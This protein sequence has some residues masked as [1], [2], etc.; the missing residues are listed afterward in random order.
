ML[1]VH[2]ENA[3]LKQLRRS[4][5]EHDVV[6]E[7]SG[8][9]LVDRITHVFNVPVER[10]LEDPHT[11]ATA[12]M[13]VRNVKSASLSLDFSG[14]QLLRGAI[15]TPSAEAADRIQKTIASAQISFAQKYSQ[16]GAAALS[17]VPPRL[18]EPLDGTLKEALHDFG[19]K[20]MEKSVTL[21]LP[22]PKSWP[23]LVVAAAGLLGAPAN[24]TK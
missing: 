13:V 11:D 8:E 12:K 18:R 23:D 4:D 1:D 9:A 22:S 10:F 16:N 24:A 20:A 5:F 6:F 7:Y 2:K 17:Q 15:T 3:L 14:Q 19:V 21:S